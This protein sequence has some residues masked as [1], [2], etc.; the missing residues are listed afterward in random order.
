MPPGY[1]ESE[2]FGHIKGAFSGAVADRR[3][4]F[5]LADGGTLF[6]DEVGELPLA[7]QSKLLRALQ[8]GDIQRVGS[9]SN[10]RV[11]VRIVAATNRDLP[12]EV[13][14]G[15]FRADLYHRL[16]VFPVR[17]PRCASVNVT[18]YCSAVIFLSRIG[19]D[20]VYAP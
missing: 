10:H 13:R 20:S 17:A 15:R 19:R 5:D 7:A 4:K 18:S 11:N 9:D 1:I 3:G 16:V 12:E 14:A 2:L 6:L 8:S